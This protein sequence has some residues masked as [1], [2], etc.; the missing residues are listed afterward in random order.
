M[1][2]GSDTEF[3]FERVSFE[4]AA[5]LFEGVTRELDLGLVTVA[6]TTSAGK[7]A[8]VILNQVEGDS[9]IVTI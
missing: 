8:L 3:R 1:S 7:P 6:L 2:E 4:Q 5:E 9:L